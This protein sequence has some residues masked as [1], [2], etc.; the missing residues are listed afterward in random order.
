[1]IM[2]AGGIAVQ[3]FDYDPDSATYQGKYKAGESA[4]L[5]IAVMLAAVRN[6]DP[7]ELRPLDETIDTDALDGMMGFQHEKNG[8]VQVTFSYEDHVI[9]VASTGDVVISAPTDD[10]SPPADAGLVYS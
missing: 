7:I 1:M 5:A 9:T 6:Q 8:D 3:A 10:S 2:L 4:S